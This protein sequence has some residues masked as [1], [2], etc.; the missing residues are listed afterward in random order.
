[1]LTIGAS[2]ASAQDAAKVGLTLSSGSTIGL[3]VPLGDRAAIRPTLGFSRTTSDYIGSSF[4]EGSITSTVLAPGASVIFYLKSLDA[5]RLYFS[6]QYT[7]SRLSASNDDDSP[8]A[9]HNGAFMIGAQ[10]GLGSRFGVYAEGGIGWSYSKNIVNTQ[11]TDS[12]IKTRSWS[13]RATVGG[14]LFF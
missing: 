7:Y 11:L 1:M 13:T 3:H 14:M 6:P 9:G 12:S 5:T 4:V 10:H 8:R 2:T